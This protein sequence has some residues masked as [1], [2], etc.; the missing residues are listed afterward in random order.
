MHFS[1]NLFDILLAHGVVL[2][3][4]L[5]LDLFLDLQ[6]AKLLYLIVEQDHARSVGEAKVSLVLKSLSLFSVK[7]AELCSHFVGFTDFEQ[8]TI[9]V[10][11]LQVLEKRVGVVLQFPNFRAHSVLTLDRLSFVTRMEVCDSVVSFVGLPV[12]FIVLF[13]D[14]YLVVLRDLNIPLRLSSERQF[15]DSQRG[16]ILVQEHLVSR[17]KLVSY[18]SEMDESFNLLAQ[19]VFEGAI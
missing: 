9:H 19:V 2:L 3:D 12:A 10:L 14:L 7:Q 1:L 6:L 13:H 18:I 17:L 4:H 16:E 11:E 15:L 5:L 8:I